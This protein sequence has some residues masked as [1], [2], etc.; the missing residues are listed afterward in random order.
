MTP[1]ISWRK[2]LDTDRHLHILAGDIGFWFLLDNIL[3]CDH[4][5]QFCRLP[6]NS[7]MSAEKRMCKCLS[8]SSQLL[9]YIIEYFTPPSIKIPE[10]VS[11][12][13]PSSGL[14]AGCVQGSWWWIWRGILALPCDFSV[15][16]VNKVFACLLYQ[17]SDENCMF[18]PAS[19]PRDQQ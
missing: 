17:Q 7:I 10:I 5:P 8:L 19:K 2:F 18:P 6:P 15:T 16:T 4:R 3:A 9:T 12:I 14:F 11:F 1:K 13:L